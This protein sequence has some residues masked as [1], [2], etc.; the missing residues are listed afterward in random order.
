VGP[1]PLNPL[2]RKV[3][4]W[5]RPSPKDGQVIDEDNPLVNVLWRFQVGDRVELTVLRRMEEMKIEVTL[6]QRPQ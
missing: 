5:R 4:P 1:F 3:N 6:V 2:S